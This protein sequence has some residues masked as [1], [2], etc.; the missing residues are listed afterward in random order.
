MDW[1]YGRARFHDRRDAG[2]LL[3]RRL[4]SYRDLPGVLVLGIPR[5]GVPVASRVA[6]AI[7]APLDILIVRK[8]GLPGMEEL[9]MGAITSAG[10]PVLN[11]GVIEEFGVD[12]ATIE[13]VA[14]AERSEVQ[15]RE[16]EYRGDRP[17]T[18]L[19]GRTIILIDDGLATG[20]T[21]QA[22]VMALRLRHPA[23][24]VVAV[25]VAPPPACAELRPLV[26]QL[27]CLLEPREFLAVG[28]W[29]EDFTPT[30]DDEVR[31]VLRDAPQA[32]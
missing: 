27:V 11:R 25:P 14:A 24:I 18:E 12:R 31:A 15:R 21:M 13:R 8:L 7:Q 4:L 17:P 20:S 10:P 5:G 1:D 9:A 6:Q 30:S 2:D 26:D 19:E 23:G 16:R 22:A 28:A 32:A 3:A 29:Y